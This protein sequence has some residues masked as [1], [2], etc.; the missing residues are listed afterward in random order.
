MTMTRQK[1]WCG[2]IIE[3]NLQVGECQ[4]WWPKLVGNIGAI[5]KVLPQLVDNIGAINK[6]NGAL[7]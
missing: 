6:Q 4:F 7:L 5:N 2:K 3:I 1:E